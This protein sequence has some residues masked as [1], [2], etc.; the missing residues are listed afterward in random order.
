[1]TS[2][3]IKHQ[4]III[5]C[6]KEEVAVLGSQSLTVRT[7]SVDVTQHW[8]LDSEQKQISRQ[9]TKAE[10]QEENEVDKQTE[11]T[12]TSVTLLSAYILRDIAGRVIC[13]KTYVPS[14]Q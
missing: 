6:V 13:Y 14:S 12:W 7:V 3:D 9:R 4:L 2:E 11:S 10:T 1:M 8:T 5:T